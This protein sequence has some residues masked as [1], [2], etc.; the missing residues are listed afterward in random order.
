M[1]NIRKEDL[2]FLKKI[3]PVLNGKTYEIPLPKLSPKEREQRRLAFRNERILYKRKS[4]LSGDQII[5]FFSEKSPFKVF[6]HDE[7]WSDIWDPMN[8]GRDFDFNRGFFEQF[9]ELELDVP[10][11]PLV[12]NKAE[13]SPYC[14]FADGNKNCYLLTSSNRNEDSYYGFL[15]VDNKNAVDCIWCTNCELVYECIDCQNCYNLRYGQ[16][17]ENCIDSGFL[18]DCKGCKNCLMSIGLRNKSYHILNQPVSKEDFEKAMKYLN[19]SHE[20]YLDA[21]SRFEEMKLKMP[22]RR[23]NNFISCENV[24]GD[25]IFNSKNVYLGFDVYNSEDCAYLH[26]GLNGK[27][28]YDICFF[29]GCE[30]C[31]ESTSLIGYG[32]R[33]TNFC[34]DSSDLFYCDNCHGCKNCFGCVGLRKKQYCI[35]NKQYKQNEYE[36][37]MARIMEK[38]MEVGE[39][40]EFFPAKYSMFAYNETLAQDYFPL[41]KGEVAARGW[42]WHEQEEKQYDK[43]AVKIPDCIDDA[44]ESI[45][46]EVLSCEISGKNYKIIQ[47]EL[48]FYKRM[49][50]PL[51][52]RCPD[53]RN[54]DR[55]AKRSGRIIHERKCN[56]CA[57]D[58]YTTYGK[59]R[60]ETIYCEKCYLAAIS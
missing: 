6:S 23:A 20:N 30:L 15:T 38:M 24:Y 42:K 44:E 25:Y 19:G 49:K 3:S 46:E 39:W 2:E 32:Y 33:F 27:D 57:T 41:K 43:R 50:L 58:I 54:A 51:P 8:F 55:I 36:E 21:A 11:P 17:C 12:N 1:V 9:Y 7:W 40:G 14:N 56:H 31:Y 48:Q 59:E 4:S 28:C 10:R 47:Q 35:F 18:Y 60:P 52:R 5:S 34:R 29:D 22:I 16:N 45:C 13:N 53:A 37:L 26:E